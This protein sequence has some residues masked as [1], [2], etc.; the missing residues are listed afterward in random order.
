MEKTPTSRISGLRK[1]GGMATQPTRIDGLRLVLADI[2][3]QLDRLYLFLDGFDGIPDFVRSP[4][5]VILRS[6]TEGPWWSSGKFLGLG[7]EGLDCIYFSFDDDIRYPPGYVATLV[8][9]LERVNGAAMVGFH[10]AFLMPPY[11]S[12]MRDRVRAFFFNA[13]DREMQVDILG[14]A[15]SAFLASRL[16]LE[17]RTWPYL[18]I[19]DLMVALAA[20]RYDLPRIALPRPAGYLRP[21]ALMQPDSLA[22]RT[23]HDHTRQTFYMRKLVALQQASPRGQPP[24]PTVR[25][26]PPAV[27]D[28]PPVGP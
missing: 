28:S 18:D 3:G 8:A 2:V 23:K 5:I 11:E 4:K 26:R 15:T 21:V 22:L 12:F 7:H 14:T 27:Q 9:A 17:L 24:R 16:P 19:D 1:V 13:L 20:E 10:A 6:Q 25:Q